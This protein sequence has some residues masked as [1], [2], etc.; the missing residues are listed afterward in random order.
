MFFSVQL[1]TLC[2]VSRAVLTSCFYLSLKRSLRGYALT[3]IAYNTRNQSRNTG[4]EGSCICQ[5]F[6][7][8]TATLWVTAQH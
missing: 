1:G 5:P 3:K 6:A 4:K 8:E 2:A 7:V